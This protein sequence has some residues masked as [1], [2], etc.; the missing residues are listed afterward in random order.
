MKTWS[1]RNDSFEFES[2][3]AAG[4]E[5]VVAAATT[6]AAL[7]RK[8]SVLLPNKSDNGQSA[9]SKLMSEAPDATLSGEPGLG[10]GVFETR[11][12]E[13]FT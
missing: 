3:E 11:T 13:D 8:G 10:L 9:L 2:L 7:D 12:V 4:L 1:N 5:V 6:E